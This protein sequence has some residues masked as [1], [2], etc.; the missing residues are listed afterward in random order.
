MAETLRYPYAMIDANTDYLQ[1]E[2]IEY[3]K[4]GITAQDNVLS[5]GLNSSKNNYCNR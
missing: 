2:V 4:L 3:K 1:I 5:E